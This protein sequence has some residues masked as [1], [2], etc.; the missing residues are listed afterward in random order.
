MVL[1][2]KPQPYQLY[3]PAATAWQERFAKNI[4]WLQH[5]ASNGFAQQTKMLALVLAVFHHGSR[6]VHQHTYIQFLCKLLINRLGALFYYSCLLL[7]SQCAAIT[8]I[9]SRAWPLFIETH[10]WQ[11]SADFFVDRMHCDW[12]K[13]SHAIWDLMP[14]NRSGSYSTIDRATWCGRSHYNP[15][16]LLVAWLIDT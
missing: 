12:N 16:I 6:L 2:H 4:W 10:T 3:L 5:N 15:Y 7:F 1:F 14:L 8:S 11:N 13:G 9:S